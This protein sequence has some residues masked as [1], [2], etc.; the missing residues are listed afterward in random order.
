MRRRFAGVW[1][2]TSCCPL[3]NAEGLLRHWTQKSTYGDPLIFLLSF[4]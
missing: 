3:G 4:D 2:G 1:I